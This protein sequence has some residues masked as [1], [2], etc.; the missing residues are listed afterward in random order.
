MFPGKE[1]TFRASVTNVS[2]WKEGFVKRSE[3]SQEIMCQNPL[4]K[5]PVADVTQC[6]AWAYV[7]GQES[8]L[9]VGMAKPMSC[10]GC[11]QF[12]RG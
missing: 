1:K 12:I 4:R 11:P 3:V 6:Q 8:M 10:S 7:T 2:V 5:E 9:R